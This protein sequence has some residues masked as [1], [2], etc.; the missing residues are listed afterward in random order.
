[1]PFNSLL[2]KNENF[3]VIMIGK[4]YFR[5]ANTTIKKGP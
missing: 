2:Q 1:M 3:V 5:D 4:I